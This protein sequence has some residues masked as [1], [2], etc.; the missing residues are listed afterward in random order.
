MRR[1]RRGRRGNKEGGGA[2]SQM[3][4]T[5]SLGTYDLLSIGTPRHVLELGML[6][7]LRFFMVLFNVAPCSFATNILHTL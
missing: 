7:V 4:F 3:G 1:E 2:V 5:M 6:Q